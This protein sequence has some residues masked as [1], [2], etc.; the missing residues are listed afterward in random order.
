MRLPPDCRL[1]IA[2]PP[3]A[4]DCEAIEDALVAFNRPFLRD[5]R[6]AHFALIVRSETGA[7]KAGLDAYVY[8]EWLFIHNLWVDADLRRQGVGRMLVAAAERRAAELGCHSAWLDTFSFQAPGFYRKLGYE[9]F[10]AL[11]YPPD[12]KRF[13]LKKR[14]G[15]GG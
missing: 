9:E 1:T 5:P 11:D 7:L 6:W 4:E 10:A 15:S 3:A 13:F 2:E 8:A 14:L 12:H